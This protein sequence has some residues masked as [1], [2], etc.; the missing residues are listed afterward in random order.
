MSYVC[1]HGKNGMGAGRAL[2]VP[3]RLQG[4][5]LCIAAAGRGKAAASP[6]S[7]HENKA[8]MGC[9]LQEPAGVGC[10]SGGGPECGTPGEAGGLGGISSHSLESR[11]GW[12]AP[13]KEN[14]ALTLSA[15]KKTWGNGGQSWVQG[16]AP[17]SGR[18]RRKL[19]EGTGGGRGGVQSL[20]QNSACGRRSDRERGARA[21]GAGKTRAAGRPRERGMGQEKP[22]G[23]VAQ[24]NRSAKLS[25]DREG[26]VRVAGKGHSALEGKSAGGLV[27][28]GA[29]ESRGGIVSYQKHLICRGPANARC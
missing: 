28:Q 23:G 17:A 1:M 20:V 5:S 22:R 18:R 27:N 25:T 15:G 29:V 10:T 3:S 9:R 21:Q 8:G 7:W 19:G 11:L 2:G 12:R 24:M 26:K 13:G 14:C 16:G 4:R 6:S